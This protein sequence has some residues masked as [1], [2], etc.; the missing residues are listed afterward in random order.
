MALEKNHFKTL[1]IYERY[2][3]KTLYLSLFDLIITK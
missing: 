3:G 2:E 1:F